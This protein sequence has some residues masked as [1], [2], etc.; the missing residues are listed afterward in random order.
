MTFYLP[1]YSDR[2]MARRTAVSGIVLPIFHC[3]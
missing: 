3:N 2:Q 1:L